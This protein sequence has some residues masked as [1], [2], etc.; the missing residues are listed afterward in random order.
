MTTTTFYT[1]CL[2]L[3]GISLCG[4][5][6]DGNKTPDAAIPVALNSSAAV[7]CP[8]LIAPP[9]GS[10]HIFEAVER[11]LGSVALFSCQEGFQ[12]LGRYKLRCEKKGNVLQ[13]S[14]QEPQ[15]QAI[16]LTAHKGFRLVVIISLVSC[17][18]II[19]MLVAFTVCCVRERHLS[20][21]EETV[22]TTARDLGPGYSMEVPENYSNSNSH[23]NSPRESS[24]Y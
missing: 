19:T 17:F 7:L 15:C 4:K 14:H 18:I 2:L 6:E 3:P 11:S 8:V 10:F 20:S 22:A 5:A 12:L 13:W 24:F 1:F 16:F 9:A 21:E 23:P